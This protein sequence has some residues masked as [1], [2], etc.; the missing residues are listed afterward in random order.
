[1]KESRWLVTGA[2]GFIGSNLCAHLLD[3]GA[4]VTGLDNFST[5]REA[6]IK[7]LKA[8]PQ[9][10]NFQFYQG[11][12]LDSGAVAEALAG[13][14]ILVHLAAQVSV[15]QSIADPKETDTINRSGT[16][17]VFATAG[18][19]GV[20]KI[21]YASSCAVYGD[22]DDLPLD[23]NSTLSPLSPYADSKLANERD[24]AAMASK[25][26]EISLIGLRFF[27]IFGPWQDFNGGY[28]AVIPRWIS[29]LMAG[30]QPVAFGD[31][32][33]SRDFC[34]VSNVC[35]LIT[36]TGSGT[37]QPG[38]HVFNVGTGEA[39]SLNTLYA[40]ITDRLRAHGQN[41]A[42]DLPAYQPWR[43]GDILH[44]HGK[45]G[46]ARKTLGFSPATGLGEG[47]DSIL[48]DEYGLAPLK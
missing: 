44:S 32:S 6:N 48:R 28:A 20:K 25:N 34:H 41:P 30:E 4:H 45:I 21:I 19:A 9:S 40:A 46:L 31:G 16:E 14:G 27:N 42:F 39:V 43:D 18:E 23:E 38:A 13:I 2:A 11:D 29:L 10:Q 7:R 35:D 1:M 12:I 22:N 3:S 8:L 37:A 15:Q 26:P 33:A 36:K 24:A 47:L 5:G 17:E